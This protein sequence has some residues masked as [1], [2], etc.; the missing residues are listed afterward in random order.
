MLISKKRLYCISGLFLLLLFAVIIVIPTAYAGSFTEFP[1]YLLEQVRY[2]ALYWMIKDLTSNNGNNA[3][4]AAMVSNNAG[5]QAPIITIMMT[6]TYAAALFVILIS[7]SVKYVEQIER[8][9]DPKET[10]FK[11]IASAFMAGIVAVNADVILSK[12]VDIGE[13]FIDSVT[14]ISSSSVISRGL[15][16]TAMTG[17]E[18][19]GTLW[20]IKSVAILLIPFLFSY[21]ITLAGEIMSFSILIELGVRRAFSPF[22]IADIYSEGMRSPGMRYLK[23]YIATFLKIAMALVICHLGI[24]LQD[25]IVSDELIDGTLGGCLRYVGKTLI[26]NATVV[27]AV[28]KTGE[29]ANDVMGV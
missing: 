23:K 28:A 14:S 20:W 8:G 16:L 21:I 5:V 11:S 25:A 18:E 22:A 26:L 13:W 24:A 2:G 29:Y 4:Y 6:A 3:A 9:A 27:A 15:S 10:L 12:V 19:G 1:N 7:T 17:E